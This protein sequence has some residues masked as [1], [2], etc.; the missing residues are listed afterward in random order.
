MA[1]LIGPCPG[2][3]GSECD[4]DD[5]R[6]EDAMYPRAVR[7]RLPVA[8]FR[9]R[10][11][12]AEG[13]HSAVLAGVHMGSIKIPP[14]ASTAPATTPQG[15]LLVVSGHRLLGLHSI[16]TRASTRSQPGSGPPSLDVP[17][18]NPCRNSAHSR[19]PL[20]PDHY[21]SQLLPGIVQLTVAL[22]PPDR[23]FQRI[24]CSLAGPKRCNSAAR[25]SRTYTTTCRGTG[26][27]PQAWQR[28]HHRRMAR[29]VLQHALS[30]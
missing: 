14:G 6:Q 1:Q 23:E 7:G 28:D 10:Q 12:V 26:C 13:R 16:T 5:A 25:R 4:G 24:R 15:T 27:A 20:D 9:Y 11:L 18:F 19:E 29:R 8:D 30:L 17:G 21:V 2:R 22:T 3:P